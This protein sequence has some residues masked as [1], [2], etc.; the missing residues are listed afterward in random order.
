M[1]IGYTAKMLNEMGKHDPYSLGGLDPEE[2]LR[3]F[4]RY[5]DTRSEYQTL[6]KQSPG[7]RKKPA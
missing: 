7:L 2:A 6:S 4:E 3:H 5:K 1:N